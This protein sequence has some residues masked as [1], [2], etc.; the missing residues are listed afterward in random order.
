M[1]PV[2]SEKLDGQMGTRYGIN[3]YT[4]EVSKRGGSV[5]NNYLNQS[6]REY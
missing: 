1:A 5:F 6:M 2:A 3:F 4:K